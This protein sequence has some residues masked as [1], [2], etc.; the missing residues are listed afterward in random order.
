MSNLVLRQELIKYRSLMFLRGPLV[1]NI[2]YRP[3]SRELLYTPNIL[4]EVNLVPQDTRQVESFPTIMFS[5][6]SQPFLASEGNL[7]QDMPQRSGD[8]DADLSDRTCW[9]SDLGFRV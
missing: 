7:D 5:T 3:S 1:M 6:L 2:V 4:P 8:L 9:A